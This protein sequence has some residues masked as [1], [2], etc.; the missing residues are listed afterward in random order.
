MDKKLTILASPN[1]F[2]QTQHQ[3]ALSEGL[4]VYGIESIFGVNYSRPETKDVACWGWRVGQDLR[5]A[6]YNVFVMERGYIGDRFKYSSLGWNGLN[7]YADFPAFSDDGQR[8]HSQGGVIKPWK[9]DGNYILILGQVK[10]DASLKGLDLT[11]WYL[12]T[13]QKCKELYN[14]PVY[15]RPHPEA[16]RRSGYNSVYGIENLDGD[17]NTAIQGALFTVAYNSNSCLDSILSGVPCY[18]GDKG[19]MAY[20][21]CMKDIS[22]LVY[23]DRERVVFDIACKQ[24]SLDEISTGEALKG[25]IEWING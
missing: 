20:D 7:N 17:L 4:L 3:K 2:H 10:N 5:N 19:T 1:S 18:A 11:E 22:Q 23:P 6:G 24:W 8:F 15:F 14:L 16:K 9:S 21:L 13:A 25:H 12:S